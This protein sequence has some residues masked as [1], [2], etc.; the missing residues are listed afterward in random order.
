MS[1]ELSQVSSI[2]D[3]EGDGVVTSNQLVH[4]Y[5]ANTYIDKVDLTAIDP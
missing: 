4:V 3:R 5:V 1:T 2:T